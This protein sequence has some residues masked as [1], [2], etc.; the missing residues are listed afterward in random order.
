MTTTPD[1]Q[2]GQPAPPAPGTAAPGAPDQPQ[3][4]APAAPENS[5]GKLRSGIVGVGRRIVG[6]VIAIAVIAGLGYAYDRFTGDPDVAGVGDCLV[7]AGADDLKVVECSDATAQHKVLGK[8]DGT[9]EASFNG[10]GGA[11]VCAPYA[12]TESAFWKGEKSGKGYVLCLGP[13]K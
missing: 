13:A 12:E 11:Q 1:Q 7:G 6:A 2:P 9:S 8:V 5:G 3:Y 10:S 4:A